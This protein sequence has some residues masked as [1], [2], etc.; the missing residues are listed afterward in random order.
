MLHRSAMHSTRGERGHKYAQC[1]AD[2]N[3]AVYDVGP[4]A[5]NDENDNDIPGI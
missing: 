1:C 3:E 4:K 5:D 2:D